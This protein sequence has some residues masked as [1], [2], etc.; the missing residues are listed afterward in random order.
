[1]KA[2]NDKSGC[3]YCCCSNANLLKDFG[4]PMPFDLVT[5]HSIRSREVAQIFVKF[6]RFCSH[7]HGVENS[8]AASATPKR[9][10]SEPDIN[11]FKNKQKSAAEGQ[12]NLPR[13]GSRDY[14]P[15]ASANPGCP[16]LAPVYRYSNV[17]RSVKRPT[18]E[19]SASSAASVYAAAQSRHTHARARVSSPA[20]VERANPKKAPRYA[21]VFNFLRQRT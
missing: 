20:S 19:A 5:V 14:L 16:S 15:S 4:L 9:P 18:R 7:V 6:T 17:T 8:E 3:C 11:N 2:G 10:L 21:A 12:P 13:G 1:M